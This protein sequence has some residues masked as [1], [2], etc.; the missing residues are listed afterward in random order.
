MPFRSRVP[1]IQNAAIN[2]ECPIFNREL[3]NP[4]AT[5]LPGKPPSW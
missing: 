1:T 2:H 5:P 4:C 3:E